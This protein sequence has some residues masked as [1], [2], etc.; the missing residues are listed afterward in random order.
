MSPVDLY[1]APTPGVIAS[2]CVRPWVDRTLDGDGFAPMLITHPEPR[3]DA[4]TAAAIE[5]RMLGIVRALG[6]APAD[7]TLPDVG[8]R[9]AV[10]NGVVLVRLD[11]TEHALTTRAGHWGQ[12]ITEIG[13]VLI[14]V[15][16]DPLPAAAVGPAV[17]E[18]LVTSTK[19]GRLYFAAAS[20]AVPARRIHTRAHP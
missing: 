11:G 20:V 2:L 7:R 9:I 14:A 15:G 4:D 10:H 1:P 16:L 17:D 8:D 12:V 13:H 6:A 5:A 19:S 3:R 18:Y